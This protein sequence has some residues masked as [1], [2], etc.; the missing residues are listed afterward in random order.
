MQHVG[1]TTRG[2]ADSF[3]HHVWLRLGAYP[4]CKCM[5]IPSFFVCVI[6]HRCTCC[7]RVSAHHCWNHVWWRTL[8][9]SACCRCADTH[10][11]R[12]THTH[13]RTHTHTPHAICTPSLSPLFQPRVSRLAC[14]RLCCYLEQRA[15]VCVCVCMCLTHRFVG[16]ITSFSSPTQPPPS[17]WYLSTHWGTHSHG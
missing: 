3:A 10:T 13:T 11:H 17:H 15:C 7:Q 9:S 4:W 5:T 16:S 6:S 14:S 12:H 2:H 8:Y 1:A